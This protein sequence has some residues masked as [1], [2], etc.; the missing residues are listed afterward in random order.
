VN[1][2][3]RS[4]GVHQYGRLDAVIGFADDVLT[5]MELY[6]EQSAGIEQAHRFEQAD[7]LEQARGIEQTGAIIKPQ[8]APSSE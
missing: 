1:A 5:S 3:H 7:G 4:Y 6:A 8:R 2:N